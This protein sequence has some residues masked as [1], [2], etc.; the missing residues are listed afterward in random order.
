MALS[1]GI[2]L[3]IMM[4]AACIRLF[5]RLLALLMSVLAWP[6]AALNGFDLDNATVARD[7]IER[8][9]PPRDGIPAIDRPRF[10]AAEQA[11]FL[12][13]GDRV[14]GVSVAGQARAYPLRILNWHEIV[15]DRF[16]ATHVLVTYCPLCGSG[17]VFRVGEEGSP[18]R[19]GVSG[20]L[21]NSDMLLYDR[22]TE[23]LWSQIEGR[24]ISGPLVGT[25]LTQLPAWSTTWRAWRARHP[26]SLV[27][28]RDTGHRRDYDRDPYA[29]Y[30]ETPGVWFPLAHRDL[31]LGPKETVVG[32]RLGGVAKAYPFSALARSQGEVWDRVGGRR[33]RVRFDREAASAEVLDEHGRPLAATTLFWFAWAAFYPD[34]QVWRSEP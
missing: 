6:A 10:V 33:L 22:R 34:T 1:P 26:D 13:P 3:P 8:G 9:G 5:A 21:Y 4:H 30:A 2:G 27:L 16:G 29:A 11:E 14:L 12:A 23:S 31:R 32:V 15:N 24:A 20:L 28:S 18:R 7:L 19:F 25:V 17:M